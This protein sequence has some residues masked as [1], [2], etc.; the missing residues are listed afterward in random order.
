MTPLTHSVRVAEEW[1]RSRAAVP[2]IH[3]LTVIL[4]TVPLYRQSI[5]TLT[6]WWG[7]RFEWA[8]LAGRKWIRQRQRTS[9]S[10]LP[11]Q[12]NERRK[13]RSDEGP[14][15]HRWMWSREKSR[16]RRLDCNGNIYFP[17]CICATLIHHL[18]PIWNNFNESADSVLNKKKQHSFDGPLTHPEKLCH[19]DATLIKNHF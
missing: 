14:P 6:T 18:L 8:W 13:R 11:I 10:L 3:S 16:W 5:M 2:A 17:C 9:L 15:L 1:G 4:S 7:I 19:S 12:W